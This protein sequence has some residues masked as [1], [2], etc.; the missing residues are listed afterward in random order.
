VPVIFYVGV[1]NQELSAKAREAGAVAVIQ[2]R[3]A[4]AVAVI[5]QRDQLLA[6]IRSVLSDMLA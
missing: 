4:G 3:E 1:A 2:P 6:S 5:Q